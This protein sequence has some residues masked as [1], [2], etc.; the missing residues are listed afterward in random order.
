[1][2]SPSAFFAWRPQRHKR[3]ALPLYQLS[4]ITASNNAVASSGIVIRL[5]LA[6]SHSRGL[7]GWSSERV[8]AALYHHL[9]RYFY[10]LHLRFS[11]VILVMALVCCWVQ[12][13]GF[14]RV[15]DVSCNSDM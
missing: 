5:L 3:P 10:F 7:K 8:S 14:I 2:P 12:K 9:R 13:D 6:H 4:F 15:Y 11:S 1:M